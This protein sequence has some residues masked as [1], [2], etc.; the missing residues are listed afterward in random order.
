MKI[1]T[2]NIFSKFA[3]LPFDMVKGSV[4]ER[5]KKAWKCWNQF[6][7]NFIQSDV[8]NVD[9]FNSALDASIAP[10]KISYTVLK[11]YRA[12]YSGSLLTKIK[13]MSDKK[14]NIVVNH[15]G[16][17]FRLPLDKEQNITN[18]LTAVHEARHFFENLFHPK[19]AYTRWQNLINHEEYEKDVDE[20][21]KL[22]MMDYQGEFSKKNFC[23]KFDEIISR[24]PDD[25]AI[26][27]LQKNRYSLKSE[28]NATFS[29]LYFLLKNKPLKKIVYIIDTLLT[30]REWHFSTREKILER[31]LKDLLTKVRAEMK[32]SQPLGL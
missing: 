18:D 5:D 14:G 20:F 27:A 21:R 29:E 9:S 30:I 25:V 11:E 12:C 10:N 1:R 22:V 7:D 2:Q 16:Y 13:T 4:K 15:Y 24:I 23:K 6:V 26:D 8:Y 17:R 3:M 28:R 19:A 32:N 31:K